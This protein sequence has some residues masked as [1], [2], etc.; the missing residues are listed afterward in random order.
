MVACAYVYVTWDTLACRFPNYSWYVCKISTHTSKL[1]CSK[2][3]F[4]WKWEYEC[5]NYEEKNYKVIYQFL[6]STYYGPESALNVGDNNIIN[7]KY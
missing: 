6:S 7:K 1:S 4:L 2:I 5:G 3:H